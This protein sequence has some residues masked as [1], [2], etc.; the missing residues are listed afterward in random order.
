MKTKKQRITFK[1]FLQRVK[2]FID[3]SDKRLGESTFYIFRTD[4]HAVLARNI[5][6]YETAKAKAN[7]LRKSHR[8]KWSQVSFKS[9]GKGSNTTSRNRI[10]VAP[11]Y[12]HSKRTHFKGGYD[13][14]G[15]YYDID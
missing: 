7:A 10:D 2:S 11:N 8:L 15:N 14:S 5:E 9:E 4:T 13:K 1:D 12:N 6:G 3:V